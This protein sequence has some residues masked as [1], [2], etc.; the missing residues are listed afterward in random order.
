[1]S[2]AFQISSVLLLRM[3]QQLNG[4]SLTFL[5]KICSFAMP[6]ICF[7]RSLF[8]S[9]GPK[10]PCQ[11][12]HDFQLFTMHYALCLGLKS[13]PLDGLTSITPH[14]LSTRLKP[15][16]ARL[17]LCITCSH[18]CSRSLTCAPPSTTCVSHDLA[19]LQPLTL[20]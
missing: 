19:S 18:L 7:I 5:H 10:L 17:N 3:Q 9:T 13:A 12:S 4:C 14:L 20:V 8:C 11:D 15:C 16:L 1:M 6:H 2:I